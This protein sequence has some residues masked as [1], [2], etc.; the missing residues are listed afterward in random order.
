MKDTDY[1]D[2]HIL[3]AFVDGE[4][5]AGNRE[6]I[7]QAMESDPDLRERVYC[8]RRSRDLMKLGFGDATPRSSRTKQQ[9]RRWFPFS[10][11]LAA[12]IAA[13]AISFGAGMLGHLYFQGQPGVA[14][15]LLASSGQL[16][17]D[18][19][20]V[21]L[22]ISESNPQQFTAA[23]T[24]AEKFLQE[25]QSQ[26]YQIDVVAHASGLDFMREDVSPLKQQMVEM[27]AKYD[28]VHFIGCANAIS[29]LRKK[30]IEPAIIQ[31]VSTDS[32]AFDHIVNRLQSGNWKYIKVESLPEV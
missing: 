14:G 32:T 21:I 28:N 18:K 29:M 27:L 10:T 3:G 16:Q 4:V 30:G 15:Q 31:G 1:F 20:N 26:G 9:H 12:S 19:N 23:I 6:A 13:L 22:H 5:D 8:L 17:S 25:H 11:R 7:I 24:Y 2:D